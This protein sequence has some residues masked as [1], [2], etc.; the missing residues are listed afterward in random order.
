MELLTPTLAIALGFVALVWGADRFVMGAAATARNLGVSPLVIGLTIVGF[1]TSAPEMLVSSVAA[2]EG[3]AGLSVGN[4]IGSNITNVALVL[5]VA[6]LVS[7][8]QVPQDV[9]SRELPVMLLVMLVAAGLLSDG[10]LGRADG[11]GLLAGMVLMVAFVVREG[12]RSRDRHGD[13]AS[14][15]DADLPRPMRTGVALLWLLAGLAVLLVGSRGL[16]WGAT[17]VARHFGVSELVI[18]L[19]IVAFGTSL[20]ELA[21]TVMAARKNEHEI[22]V[23]NVI[24][25]NLFNTLGVLGLPGVIRPGPVDANVMQRDVPVMLGVSVLLFVLARTFRPYQHINRLEGAALVA[26][27]LGW[28]LWIYLE[29]AGAV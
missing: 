9:L 24:G 15:E 1:G 18:G 10:H 16:V 21:A 25:S 8:L 20:P 6:A 4:A 2:L 13:A 7:P 14:P 28:L 27:F 22:A 26:C 23:G 12:L 29:T 19:T 3:A 11:A 5:G 17:T